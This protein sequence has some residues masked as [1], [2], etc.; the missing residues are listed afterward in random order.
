MC[1]SCSLSS[2]GVLTASPVG[3]IPSF[4]T[5]TCRLEDKVVGIGNKN[6]PSGSLGIIIN[7]ATSIFF[8][9]LFMS[10]SIQYTV[11]FL[12]LPVFIGPGI[13]GING[14]ES[15]CYLIQL[16]LYFKSWTIIVFDDELKL[17]LPSHF[18]SVWLCMN[19][20]KNLLVIYIRKTST[21]ASLA[22][23]KL[24]TVVNHNQLWKTLKVMGAPDHLTCLL[25]NLYLSQEATVRTEH[26]T[27]DGSKLVKAVYCHPAYLT[28][29][30][31]D[32]CQAG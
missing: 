14:N 31:H 20:F 23:L 5:Q 19:F 3:S 25:K 11:L 24:L 28:S 2:C 26:E 18:S 1:Y 30:H 21:S 7:G 27:T 17:L 32:K 4:E 8:R 29:M 16:F 9:R 13:W 15:Y 10:K 12:L 6:F 22:T